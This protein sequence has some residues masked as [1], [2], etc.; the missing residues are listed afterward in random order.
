MTAL[1]AEAFPHFF[2]EIHG[3][4][5]FPWQAR[6]AQELA[7][8]GHWPSLLD[9]PTSAGK[10]ASIDIA[11]FHLAL[12]AE[13]G[14]QRKAPL[15]VLFVVDRRL[16]V[17][18]AFD[19][20]KTIA[21]RLEQAEDGLLKSVADRLRALAGSGAPSL[22][23]VRLRGGV[24]RERDWARSP[25]QPL[26]AVSTVD[27]V[28]SRLLF[29]GYGVSPRMWPVHAGLVGADAL[30]LLDEVHLSQPFAETLG[31]IDRGHK[32]EGNGVLADL[33]RLAPF[34][35]VKLSATPGETAG[36]T[37][38]LREDDQNH[39]VLQP[40][41]T[42]RKLVRLKAWNEDAAET[43]VTSA[44]HLGGLEEESAARKGRKK[45]EDV[46]RILPVK[47][48]GVVVNRVDLA[49]QI[50]E[51]LGKTLGERGKVLL[52]TGRI[53]PLDRDRLLCEIKPLFTAPKRP[54][55]DPPIILVA[56][57]TVEA[58]ADL[59]M[60]A[61]V[62]EI[63]PLDSLRQRFGRLD[64]LGEKRDTRAVVLHPPGKPPKDPAKERDN[65]WIPIVRIYGESPYATK[66]WLEKLDDEPDFGIDGLA[67]VLEKMGPK[68]E[69]LLAPRARAPALLPPYVDL[70]ATTS[71]APAATP[72]PTLFLHGPDISAGIQ[73]AWRSD[74]DLA[75]EGSANLSLGICP[76][77]S[78]EAM[79]VPLWAARKWLRAETVDTGV[80]DVP[81]RAP[82]SDR[83]PAIG[84]PCLKR[85]G[86][87]WIKAFADDLRPGDIVVVPSDFGG[88]DGFG[89][90]PEHRGTVGDLGAEAHY[91]QRLKGALRV[92]RKTL[93]NVLIGGTDEEAAIDASET[94]RDI[95]ALIQEVGDDLDAER[96][97]ASLTEIDHLPTIWRSLLAAMKGRSVSI[98][99]YDDDDRTKGFLLFAKR[100]LPQ[101]VLNGVDEGE[102]GDDSVTDQHDSWATGVRVELV[103]HLGHVETKARD[104]ARLA[105]LDSGM[106][107]LL[108]L[109]GRM[110]DLGKADP[111]FQA[112]LHG[113]SALAR[114]GLLDAVPGPML[115]KS[116]QGGRWRPGQRAAP[117]NFRHEALSVALAQRHPAVKKLDED[118]RD[119]VLW[120]VGTHHG[121][122]RPFFPPSSD[123]APDTETTLEI[124]DRGLFAK[125]E[126]APL[127]LDQG[128]FERAERLNRRFG[129]WELARLEAIVRLAD[130]AASADEQKDTHRLETKA[131]A[132]EAV[133]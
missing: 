114:L 116:D 85:S 21:N 89:W 10:T 72:E 43:F 74:I 83:S 119:L 40:R 39:P 16:V 100:A 84:R 23:V 99:F 121:Y 90:N 104:L 111:R 70:W 73:I 96:T 109:A 79:P 103:D 77:S 86:E 80:A 128:W 59:D 7:E 124:D 55:P 36:T 117:E 131:A 68:L 60:D 24:P 47:R 58:G 108:A 33:P 129:P 65:P 105:G 118:D 1:T 126:E 63:A 8:T 22:E 110:H 64:R 78:L 54:D 132:T 34:A 87:R 49:R 130:H 56:T 133:S 95:L 57:Q 123:P 26:V 46:Q 37:F 14:A 48:I 61:L 38:R 6:L 44:L 30:W 82:E 122:G 66:E 19:R 127:R 5:P 62:T 120:L 92:T 32:A 93:A 106:T 25:A 94:W 45:A 18:S 35:V 69:L 15:R 112:D 81:D 91:H 4:E 76:P 50:F 71:P 51:K 12:E 98:E 125:A 31:A 101:K 113:A 102:A 20:A 29:R 3:Y 115:A 42:A 53:R 27:Q 107:N 67:P 2:R 28:G 17:D 97:R 41:L 52:L 11:V 75:D 9:L 88:C 13:K